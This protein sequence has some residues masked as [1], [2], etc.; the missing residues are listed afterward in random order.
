MKLP[1]QSE[2]NPATEASLGGYKTNKGP[3][4]AVLF[5]DRR[6]RRAGRNPCLTAGAPSPILAQVG[7]NVK[8]TATHRHL[9]WRA[10]SA[11]A[12]AALAAVGLAPMAQAAPEPE[13]QPGTSAAEEPAPAAEASS[14]PGMT[15][16]QAPADEPAPASQPGTTAPSAPAEPVA[17]GG[18]GSAATTLATA[19][20]EGGSAPVPAAGPE[21][22]ADEPPAPGT[23]ATATPA[24]DDE[25]AEGQATASDGTNHAEVAISSDDTRSS[26]ATEATDDDTPA[27]PAAQRTGANARQNLHVDAAGTHVATGGEVTV[28]TPASGGSYRIAATAYATGVGSAQAGADLTAGGPALPATV[29]N[30]PADLAKVAFELFPV[31]PVVEFY[32]AVDWAISGVEEVTGTDVP[33]ARLDGGVGPANS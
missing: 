14:Q 21:P 22:A 28:T 12:M 1:L 30:F 4:P 20:P 8:N 33:R 3:P 19:S 5:G 32:G 26:S 9:V 11:G 17:Q 25:P 16:P 13:S 18:Q 15:Q 31:D 2:T 27:A 7:A 29:P 10:T 6:W 24:T 23:T